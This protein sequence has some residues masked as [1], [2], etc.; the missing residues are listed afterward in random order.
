MFSVPFNLKCLRISPV[1]VFF[2]YKLYRVLRLN[3]HIFGDFLNIPGLLI[4]SLTPLRSENTF[5]IIFIIWS[6]WY[7]LYHPVYGLSGGGSEVELKAMCISWFFLNSQASRDTA[8]YPSRPG[9]LE[10]HSL[11]FT[12]LLPVFS[13]L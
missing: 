12:V 4:I 5:C 11:R 1:I 7:I 10:S 9:I 3:F 8:L 6:F 13:W 2:I